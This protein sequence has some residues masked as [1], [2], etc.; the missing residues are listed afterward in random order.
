MGN[1]PFSTV[2]FLMQQTLI[3]K[4]QAFFLL[5]EWF[6]NYSLISLCRIWNY[7]I[8]VPEGQPHFSLGQKALTETWNNGFRPWGDTFWLGLVRQFVRAHTHVYGINALFLP[9]LKSS[10]H[11]K[12]HNLPYI[13]LEI[14][15]ANILRK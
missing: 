5:L 15:Y 1:K 4:A 10:N 9:L 8:I 3:F 13:S 11:L 2:I 12:I 7:G 6:Q 14:F